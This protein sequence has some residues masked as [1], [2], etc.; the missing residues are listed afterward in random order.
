MTIQNEPALVR[1]QWLNVPTNFFWGASTSAYQIEGAVSEDGRGSSIWDDFCATPGAILG[2]ETGDVAVDHYH[3]VKEDIAL[4]KQ[5]GLNSYCFSVSWSRVFPSGRGALNRAGLDFYDRLVDT[6]LA[7]GITPITKLYHW[8]LPSVLQQSGGW[9]NR[10]TAYA[11]ADYAECVAQRLGDRVGWWLTHNEPWCTSYLGHVLGVHAPGV[12]DVQLGVYSA[13]HVLLSHGLAM[14][15]VRANSRPDAQ[16]GITLDYYPVH[17]YDS[18]PETQRAVESADAFR[19]RW[20]FD[21][22][23]KKQYPSQLFTDFGVSP[24]EV[25]EGDFELIGAPIDFLG[26]NYYTRMVVRAPQGKEGGQAF[27][28]VETLPGATYTGMQWEIY[29]EGLL[30]GLERIQREYAPRAILITE[31]GAAFPDCW[32]GESVVADTERMQYLDQHIQRVGEAIAKGI[33]IRGYFAWSLLDN[34]EWAW[35][36]SKRFGIIYVDF[37]S[38]KRIIKE[39]G[40]WYASF[41][42]TLRNQQ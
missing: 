38:Q 35:G 27:E 7:N 4:L 42:A 37:S 23:F 18:S 33:P 2:N 14:Q 26:L 20:F 34:F 8:D 6:L 30:E 21:P 13:H 32:D 10:D 17:A 36:Y 39:S 40:H 28:Q 41:I 9:V 3:R 31:S 22:I 5:L 29:P 24:P 1:A 16:V 11:F 25:H 12:K 15:R 19:N